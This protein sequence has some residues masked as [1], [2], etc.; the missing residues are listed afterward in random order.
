VAVEAP[1]SGPVLTPGGGTPLWE[2]GELPML[3]PYADQVAPGSSRYAVPA[4][5]PL[6]PP[7]AV[8]AAAPANPYAGGAPAGPASVNPYAAGGPG[9]SYASP[10][11]PY[12]GQPYAGQ[13]YA[14]QPYAGQPYAGQPYAGQ[15][16]AG[17]PAKEGSGPGDAM[18]WIVPIGRSGAS[19]AAGYVGLVS[20]FVWVLG[21]AAIGLGI[22]GLRKARTGGHGSG[23]SVFGIVTGVLATIVGVVVLAGWLTGG[24]LL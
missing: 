9:P 24:S 18:H 6:T 23:R 21:P 19:I 20:L 3:D 14:G 2:P 16:Y 1:S 15:P 8:V 12:A 17:P 13:P 22:W 10:Q 4:P 7:R 11:Q 5:H